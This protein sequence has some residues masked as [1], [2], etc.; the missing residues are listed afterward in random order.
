MFGLQIIISLREKK[1]FELKRQPIPPGE[2]LLEE[3]LKPY[4][5]SQTELAQHLECDIKTI[6]R[7]VKARQGVTAEMALKLG[8]FFRTTPEFWLNM[9]RE[10]D[11]YEARR[12]VL[13]LPV[14]VK[15]TKAIGHTARSPMPNTNSSGRQS[16]R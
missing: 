1:M 2:I 7:I 12:K 13:H 9:Q 14:P 10:V 16:R 8:G 11:L 5:M 6:N 4:G 3:F 15:R